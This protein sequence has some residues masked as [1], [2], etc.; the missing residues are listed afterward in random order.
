MV[1]IKYF[2]NVISII[3]CQ[4]FIVVNGLED[5]WRKEDS[6]SSEF[7]HYN[8]SSGTRSTIGRVYTDIEMAS[9]TKINHIRYPLLI[10]IM[11]FF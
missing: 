8:K 10:I 4:K 11:S 3:P 5:L 7:T 6:D 9:N 2:I 1:E